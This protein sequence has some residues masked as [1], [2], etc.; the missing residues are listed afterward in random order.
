MIR[1]PLPSYELLNLI[2]TKI[3]KM[4]SI[5]YQLYY[6]SYGS[7]QKT[8]LQPVTD[9]LRKIREIVINLDLI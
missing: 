3:V 9:I 1:C 4:W 7:I 2:T 8:K 5:L 6:L